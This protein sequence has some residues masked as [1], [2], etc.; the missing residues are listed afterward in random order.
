MRRLKEEMGISSM[1]FH[2]FRFLYKAGLDNG[3]TEHE[4]DHVFF[5]FSDD[6]PVPDPDEVGD[7]RYISMD[8]LE[9]EL[10][11]DPAA[12]TVWLRLIFEQVKTARYALAD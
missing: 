5:A 10:R 11:Q 8:R 1:V 7:W 12:F 6:I 2:Q 9:T 4:L 3:L